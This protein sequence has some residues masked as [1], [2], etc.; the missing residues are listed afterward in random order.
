MW[1]F[2]MKNCIQP[3][4]AT[5]VAAALAGCASTPSPMPGAGGPSGAP[6]ASSTASK[7]RIER[8]A[9]LPR[10]SYPVS[11]DLIALMNNPAQFKPLVEKIRQ[12]REN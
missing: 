9:D 1:L 2:T 11:G 7:P 10:F 5:L 8:A 3:L 4:L 12:Y 6:A